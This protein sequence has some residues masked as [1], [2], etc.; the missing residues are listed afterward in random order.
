MQL[1][2]TEEMNQSQTSILPKPPLCACDPFCESSLSCCLLV[3]H[4]FTQLSNSRG[5]KQARTLPPSHNPP[6]FEH[7]FLPTHTP[8]SAAQTLEWR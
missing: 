4:A 2:G 8:S 5:L 1:S 3:P 6:T 7:I